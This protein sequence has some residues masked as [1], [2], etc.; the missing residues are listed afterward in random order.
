VVNHDKGKV[1]STSTRKTLEPGASV[2]IRYNQ[3]VS[4]IRKVMEIEAGSKNGEVIVN[5]P[6]AKS[7]TELVSSRKPFG[8]ATTFRG[9]TKAGKS[10]L[11]VYQNGGIGYVPRAEI[12][13]G[14]E[15]ID[16][17][18]VFIPRAGSGS[19]AFPHP[20]LGK[21]FIGAPGTICSETYICIG[22]LKSEDEARNVCTYLSTKLLRFL[23][24]LHKP[25]QDAARAVYTFVPT[26]DFSQLWS[27][28]LLYK[29]YGISIEEIDFINS[30][31]RPM[32]LE[33]E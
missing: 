3:G 11:L 30:M 28:D 1:I 26:Q 10:E 31:I 2:F 9:S 33:I 18:K 13:T 16:S 4:I 5:L 25:S 29:K 19:D 27:D 21:P 17:W 23:V 15:F 14:N 12:S 6:K 8:L 24:L 20:I 32:E 7:F 22:P